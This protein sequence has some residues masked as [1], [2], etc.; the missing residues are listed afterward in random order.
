MFLS[1]NSTMMHKSHY[2]LQNV[3]LC[4]SFRANVICLSSGSIMNT[5]QTYHGNHHEII[6][7]SFMKENQPNRLHADNNF[8]IIRHLL[9]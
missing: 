4:V 1:D 2:F 8:I 9:I 6:F 3:I 7:H 5:I